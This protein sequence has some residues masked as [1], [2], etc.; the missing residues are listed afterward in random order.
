MRLDSTI[1]SCILAFVIVAPALAVSVP[2]SPL[3]DDP[4]WTTQNV[5]IE[6][7]DLVAREDDSVWTLTP[8]S[9]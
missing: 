1:V 8:P 9:P 7:K 3:V 6:D 4:I 5:D 2:K